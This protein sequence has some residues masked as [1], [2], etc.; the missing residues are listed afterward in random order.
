MGEEKQWY[1]RVMRWTN[2]NKR[3][4]LA[5]KSIQMGISLLLFGLSC[6]F[7]FNYWK[8][9]DREDVMLV[10]IRL[11]IALLAF[12]IGTFLCDYIMVIRRWAFIIS[13]RYIICSISITLAAMVFMNIIGEKY[14]EGSL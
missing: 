7:Y 14:S 9:N 4:Y 11:I 2:N 10:T 5:L 8:T 3:G 6:L 12:D 13:L 1:K